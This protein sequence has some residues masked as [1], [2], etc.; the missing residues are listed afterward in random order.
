[1][2]DVTKTLIAY[3]EG[4]STVTA[5]VGSSPNE[6]IFANFFP[7]YPS[8]D[9]PG[10]I[11]QEIGARHIRNLDNAQGLCGTLVQVSCWDTSFSGAKALAEVVRKVLDGWSETHQDADGLSDFNDDVRAVALENETAEIEFTNDKS[12]IHSHVIHQDY[13]VWIPRS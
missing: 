1:M 7:S 6:R 8:T 4:E 10:I 11:I 5:I 3:L 9:L 13:T 12:A 2:A